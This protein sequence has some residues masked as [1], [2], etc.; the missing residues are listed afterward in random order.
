MY[1]TSASRYINL[2]DIATMVRNGT[3]VQVVDAQTGEDLTRATLTQIIADRAKEE[4]AGLPLEL[5]RE[6]IVATDHAGQQFIMWYLKSAFDSYRKM[7]NA[8]QSGLS[9]LQTAALNPLSLV[10]R[11]IPKSADFS[12]APAG[13]EPPQGRELRELRERLAVLEVQLNNSK[14]VPKRKSKAQTKR[15]DGK[16][17][18]KR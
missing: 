11:F 16:R 12:Q 9:E 10:E 2:E 3:D 18:T 15:A 6:L 14:P 17:K 8:M 13:A 4:P 5:L 7:Q 1:D